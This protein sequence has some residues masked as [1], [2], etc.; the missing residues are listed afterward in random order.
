MGAG[1]FYDMGDDH[2][3]NSSNNPEAAQDQGRIVITN[4]QMAADSYLRLGNSDRDRLAEMYKIH[5]EKVPAARSESNISGQGP[6]EQTPQQPNHVTHDH[7]HDHTHR[8]EMPPAQNQTTVDRPRQPRLIE[9]GPDTDI[10][11]MIGINPEREA[12]SFD[13]VPVENKPV[14]NNVDEAEEEEEEERRRPRRQRRH[15]H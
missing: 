11:G 6:L 3:K 9:R 8:F 10:H 1:L 15:R 7:T 13:R 2:R 5:C 4:N 14:A 12:S